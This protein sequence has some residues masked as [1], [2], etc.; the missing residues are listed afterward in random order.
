MAMTN[1][2]YDT[3]QR[4]F[5]ICKSIIGDIEPK[6][7]ELQQIYDSAGGVKETL[8]QADLDSVSSLSSLTKQQV[9]DGVY[10]LTAVLLPG[11]TQGYASLSQLSARSP[12]GFLSLPI[13][14]TPP[15][16]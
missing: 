14:I 6:L 10:V 7:S 15:V 8:T 3:L 2:E 5:A 1:L 12:S 16:V 11:I 13:P 4:I 9:D